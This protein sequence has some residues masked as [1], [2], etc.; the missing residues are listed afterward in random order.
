[1]KTILHSYN[2]RF[3]YLVLQN[4]ETDNSSWLIP[5]LIE[6]HFT[7]SLSS[8]KMLHVFRGLDFFA[9]HKYKCYLCYYDMS[10]QQHISFLYFF[11]YVVG[12]NKN[13]LSEL[14]ERLIFIYGNPR[15]E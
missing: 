15:I 7:Y 2:I 4:F 13:I 11:E 8:W 9:F 6:F 12:V 3:E 5:Y 10:K 14:E 1:M